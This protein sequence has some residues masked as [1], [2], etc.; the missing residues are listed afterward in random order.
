[1]EAV[2]GDLIERVRLAH[3][4]HRHDVAIRLDDVDAVQFEFRRRNR[5]HHLRIAV[6]AFFVRHWM[7]FLGHP[8]QKRAP[9]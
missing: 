3:V 4:D 8:T 9:A 5:R 7:D 2:E 1:M 6:P